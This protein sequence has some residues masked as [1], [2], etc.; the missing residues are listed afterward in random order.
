M[1]V[2]LTQTVEQAF[3][4]L[5]KNDDLLKTAKEQSEYNS[6]P[7]FKTAFLSDPDY[8][9]WL[10]SK[11]PEINEQK[12]EKYT[13]AQLTAKRKKAN[14]KNGKRNVESGHLAS[15]RTREH[16]Q[17]ANAK[18]QESQRK[19]RA[20]RKKEFVKF[21]MDNLP[22]EF[23]KANIDAIRNN[24]LDNTLFHKSWKNTTLL[25]DYVVHRNFLKEAKSRKL[26]VLVKTGNKY[27][28]TIYHK[29][30]EIVAK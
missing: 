21:M 20:K 18:G 9:A 11:I 16:Q 1:S 28:P 13:A 27:E 25:K 6:W 22:N 5:K 30:N 29:I 10:E 19:I 23:T 15:L 2:N 7:E 17:Y 12:S 4:Y 14:R 24:N 26:V 8:V 3:N